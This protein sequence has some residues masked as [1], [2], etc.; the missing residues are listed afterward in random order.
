MGVYSC[1]HL[2]ITNT[3][4]QC[5]AR[6][7]CRQ[8][9][10]AHYNFAIIYDTLSDLMMITSS[11]VGSRIPCIPRGAHSLLTSSGSSETVP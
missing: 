10:A 8:S 3:K 2:Q 9:I 4:E 7:N 11:S 5:L 6:F 1:I